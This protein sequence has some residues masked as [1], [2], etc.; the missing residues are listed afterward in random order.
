[1]PKAKSNF[2]YDSN[3]VVGLTFSTPALIALIAYVILALVIVLPFEFPVTDERTGEVVV[4]KY[5][6]TE[7]I[8]VLILLIIPVGLSVYTINCMMVGN[9][10]LWSYIVSLISVFWVVL[11][12]ISAFVYTLNKKRV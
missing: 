12:V 4:V 6:L 2:V 3:E 7:R 5:D 8:I 10:L 9:C 1:M 11:F